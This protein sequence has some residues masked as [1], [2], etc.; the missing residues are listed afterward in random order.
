MKISVTDLSEHAFCKRKAYYN[1]SL[2]QA[3][4]LSQNKYILEK[5]KAGIQAHAKMEKCA[6]ANKN[7]QAQTDNRCFVASWACGPNH[8]ATNILRAYRDQKLLT[9]TFG[10]A[11]VHIYYFLSPIL[12]SFLKRIPGAQKAA[13]KIIIKITKA[14]S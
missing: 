1:N 12:I 2:S 5:Q 14:V 4:K 7:A 6:Y 13:Y 10:R 8:K 9:N 11:F 3:E